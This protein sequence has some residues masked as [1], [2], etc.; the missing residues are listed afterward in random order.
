MSGSKDVFEAVLI[1]PVGNMSSFEVKKA[2]ISAVD[3]AEGLLKDAVAS[4]NADLFWTVVRETKDELLFD[5]RQASDLLLGA[6]KTGC[7]QMWKAATE[8]AMQ[9]SATGR[10]GEK[11]N[12]FQVLHN[13][14]LVGSATSSC[15]PATLRAVLAFILRSL[16]V[17]MPQEAL[18]K[19]VAAAF[20]EWTCIVGNVLWR[21]QIMPHGLG[22]AIEVLSCFLSYPAVLDPGDLVKLARGS[23]EDWI[24][25]CFVETVASVENPFVPGMTLSVALAKAAAVAPRGERRKLLALQQRLDSLL[26]EILERLP[27]TVQGFE[28]FMAGCSAVF[29]PEVPTEYSRGFLGPLW[30]VMQERGHM[31]TFCTQPIIVD[32]LT[33]RFTHGLPDLLDTKHILSDHREVFALANEAARRPEYYSLSE[34]QQEREDELHLDRSLVIDVQ[35]RSRIVLME[36]RVLDTLLSPCGMLQGVICSSF[37]QPRGLSLLPGTQFV[38]AGLVAMPDAYYMV[39]AMRMGL[40]FAVYL[41]MLTLFSAVTLF[42][43]DGPLTTGELVFAFYLLAGV[44][45][46]LRELRR[47]V[48]LYIADHWNP[49]DLLGLGLAAGGFIARFADRTSSLGRVLY[50]LSAPLTFSRLLFFAQLFRFQGPMIQVIFSMIGEMIKFGVVILVVMLGFAVSFHSLFEQSNTFGQTCLTL[51]KGMPGEVGF[52]DDFRSDEYSEYEEVATALFIIFLVIIAIML[53]N[54]LVAVLSTS[55][56]KVQEKGEQEFRVSR[57]RLIDHYRLLVD[58]HLLPPPF[59]LVQLAVSIPFLLVDWSWRGSRC[60][61]AKEAVGRAIFWLV[62]G[63]TALVGGTALWMASALYAPSYGGGTAA[64]TWGP[65]QW[66]CGVLSSSCGALL[67]HRCTLRRFGLRLLL[68]GSG[69]VR[70]GGC[71]IAAS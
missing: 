23:S 18:G 32:F 39:P 3:T 9:L 8:A 46:E 47:D 71:G 55:H 70:G 57:A 33:R 21:K 50:A 51:F 27:S 67:E 15:D 6:A 13:A 19:C 63:N 1:G 38:T 56:A 54:L 35:D 29:E 36:R 17:E 45:T 62:M 60:T 43:D 66:S 20:S 30:M 34:S 22:W 11:A 40:D 16:P 48:S 53:L 10:L 25:T 59:N 2:L 58:K 49:I 42:H 12:S 28:G 68:N 41:G 7:V 14:A 31:E 37:I 64:A 61:R 24:G 69:C 5:G 65:F 52:F 26:L 44:I 4:G